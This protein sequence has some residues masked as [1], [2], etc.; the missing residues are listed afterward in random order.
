MG[1]GHEANTVTVI[2]APL[3]RGIP[4]SPPYRASSVGPAWLLNG[5]PAQCFPPV[6]G[7]KQRAAN[8]RAPFDD[9]QGTPVLLLLAS[10]HLLGLALLHR[11]PLRWSCWWK[12]RPLVSNVGW[13]IGTASVVLFPLS[14]V[15][16]L[17]TMS[18]STS[19]LPS[20]PNFFCEFMSI[21]ASTFV[22]DFYSLEEGARA[23]PSLHKYSA[24]NSLNNL[25]S[26]HQKSTLSWPCHYQVWPHLD[27]G[28]TGL[29][30]NGRWRLYKQLFLPRPNYTW[31][32]SP[33]PRT[34]SS[35]SQGRT[36]RA[37][38]Y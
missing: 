27:L 29:I 11:G 36:S 33:V 28:G 9:L 37:C 31:A 38:R 7:S 30:S 12:M 1:H 23:S 21:V 13:G 17:R 18:T 25:S 6:V 20:S 35:P 22:S 32:D 24:C 3:M 34:I 15:R 2:A 26:P 14:L 19:T 10:L 16:E 8:H 4:P 5:K